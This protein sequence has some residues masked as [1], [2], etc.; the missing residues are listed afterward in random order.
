MNWELTEQAFIQLNVFKSWILFIRTYKD[1]THLCGLYE[2][3]R[4]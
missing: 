2:F 3:N 4:I 1:M